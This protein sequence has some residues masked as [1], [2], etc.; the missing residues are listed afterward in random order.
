M[1]SLRTHLPVRSC[2]SIQIIGSPVSKELSCACLVCVDLPM[3]N[4]NDHISP[5]T[6]GTGVSYSISSWLN[7]SAIFCAWYSQIHA[8]S[9]NHMTS[10]K[11]KNF[12][13]LKASFNGMQTRATAYAYFYIVMAAF[14]VF[15]VV[16]KTHIINS[17]DVA[18]QVLVSS[19]NFGGGV[20][21]LPPN[22]YIL[23]LPVY[24]LIDL[25]NLG[26]RTEWAT[27]GILLN[28]AGLL[29]FLHAVRYFS[30]EFG[31]LKAPNLLPVFWM[32]TLT[33]TFA[34]YLMNP[35]SRNLE[36]GLG[37]WG[38]TVLH[39]LQK[40]PVSLNSAYKYAAFSF[41]AGLFFYNDPYFVYLLG[42][43]MLA[44]FGHKWVTANSDESHRHDLVFT[45]VF[46]ALVLKSFW[47][48]LFYILGIYPAHEA[49]ALVALS[50][51]GYNFAVLAEQLLV[52]SNANIFGQALSGTSSAVVI[53]NFLILVSAVSL[54]GFWLM[55]F[56]VNRPW[57]RVMVL[58]PLA[59]LVVFAISPKIIDASSGRYLVFFPYAI[60]GFLSVVIPKLSH[61]AKVVAV[62][63]L[64]FA[65]IGNLRSIGLMLNRAD[66]A[67]AADS[68][69][70][71]LVR[72]V[73]R[74][75][76]TKGYV[77]FWEGP[78]NTYF[79]DSKIAFVQAGCHPKLGL[80]VF[81]WLSD[82]S[83]SS[84][85]AMKTFYL[86][87]EEKS[88][89]KLEDLYKFTG[90]PEKTI[91]IPNENKILLFFNRDIIAE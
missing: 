53:A 57:E 1:G 24:F 31:E 12:L 83:V 76:Y 81:N 14:L 84:R 67:E 19:Y 88:L 37:L 15:Y 60:A 21:H 52:I 41:V 34:S 61:R 35:N 89:C 45:L 26:P 7:R 64:V 2:R 13:S 91:K 33:Y 62:I 90:I 43:P 36:L 80:S 11:S 39:R 3:D 27:L 6:R 79:S 32:C 18:Q 5:R 78:M 72:L 22:N 65:S 82:S 51:L 71:S 42:F 55:K 58:L 87:D 9:Y 68:R 47:N 59:C 74:N 44:V 77:N 86:H 10:P 4:Y 63:L 69:N 50:G 8:L 28:L 75:G 23:K 70:M 29:F 20:I 66:L 16:G 48:N 17:D 54:C 49:P 85:L 73:E 30:K 46:L 56:S 38:L 40:S 25:L